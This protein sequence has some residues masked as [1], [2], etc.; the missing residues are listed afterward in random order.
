MLSKA[1]FARSKSSKAEYPSSV[2]TLESS[3]PVHAV[4]NKAIAIV[5]SVNSIFLIVK[6]S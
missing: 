4:T 6:T 5:N 3:V 1:E 2:N